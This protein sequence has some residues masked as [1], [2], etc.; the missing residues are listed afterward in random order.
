MIQI[1][2]WKV[3]FHPGKLNLGLLIRTDKLKRI[4]NYTVLFSFFAQCT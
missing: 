3:D 2:A 1:Q 4:L